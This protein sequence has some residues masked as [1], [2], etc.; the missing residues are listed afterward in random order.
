MAET[1]RSASLRALGAELR[2]AREAADLG[3][4]ALAKAAEISTHSRISEL[5][6][7]KRLLSPP[8]LARILDALVL[9]VDER[10]RLLGLARAADGGA[11]QLNVGRPG[12]SATLE[13]L[14]D[15][16]RA[17]QR[18]TDASPLLI[19]GLLQTS[20]Y[21]RAIMGDEPDSE[22][23]VTLRAGRRD[24]LT[25]SDPVELLA[26]IDSEAFVRP[27]APPRVMLDQLK[28]VLQLAE[29]PN[30]T[31]QVVSSTT[32]GYHPMLAG[33]FELLQFEKATPIVLLDH[34]SSSVFLWQD[35]DVQRYV[36]AAEKLRT[37]VAMT[38]DESIG[39]I[40]NIVN[41]LETTT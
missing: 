27:V 26:L 33:A 21:A 34:H 16:E 19:P 29:R 5:E 12:I 6:A 37:Q 20:D 1:S 11:G 28:H 41:G 7:G 32:P 40:A 35:S 30:V 15:H 8:E 38:P 17:A 31:V 4:R 39:A 22:L 36:E 3:V 25:K 13:Q 10:E 24:I 14:I 2:Q 18:I 23:R 9:P